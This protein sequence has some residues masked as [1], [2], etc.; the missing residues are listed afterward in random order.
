MLLQKNWQK[1][2]TGKGPEQ[3]LHR[4]LMIQGETMKTTVIGLDFGTLSARAAAFD[5]KTGEEKA[6]AVFIYPHGCLDEKLPESGF[7][8]TRYLA[9]GFYLLHH[10]AGG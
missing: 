2:I 8:E 7:R 9:N 1:S 5:I 4:V 10:A 6:S 3:I